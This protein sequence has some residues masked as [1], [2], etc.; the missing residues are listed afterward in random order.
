MKNDTTKIIIWFL[1][2]FILVY[3]LPRVGVPAIINQIAFLLLLVYIFRSKDNV[4]WL[5]WFFVILD[6]PG[7]LFASSSG[8]QIYRLPSYGIAS[9]ISI[10]FQELFLA[11]YILKMMTKRG[12]SNF[13]F[14]RHIQLLILLGAA[15]F[16][17]SFFIGISGDNIVRTVRALSSWLWLLIIPYF[18]KDGESL[19]RALKMIIPFVFFAFLSA[20]QQYFTG[21]NISQILKGTQSYFMDL[22]DEGLIRI[23]SSDFLLFFALT[24]SIYQIASGRGSIKNGLLFLVITLSTMTI[25]LSATRGWIIGLLILYLSIFFV[26]GFTRI[27]QTLRITAIIVIII[28]I[29]ASIIPN[30][31]TQADLAFER[32]MTLEA[33]AQ[34]DLTAGGTLVRIT[35]R[36]PRVMAVWRESPII[37]WAFSNK[38]YAYGDN[39]VGNQTNLL[40]LGIL[41]FLLFNGIYFSILQKT[42]TWGRFQ[43][44]QL[45]APNTTIIHVFAMLSIFFMH[46]T[47]GAIW[48]YRTIGPHYVPQLM[49]AFL[50]SAISVALSVPYRE[51]RNNSVELS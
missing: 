35:E 26:Y 25:F 45:N 1:V 14:K 41:G 33:L 32:M 2:A 22:S 37:G 46:S 40:N 43:L 38:F 17:I 39:H 16:L 24:Q 7:N 49:L 31:S 48:I 47:S 8:S 3:G 29:I 36:S 10:S 34:G 21:L 9:G 51:N 42:Y 44:R 12:T 27:I 23:A 11:T 13:I 4:L 30:I 50:F 20:I 19:D 6:T 5:T 28:L 18:I 15:Y